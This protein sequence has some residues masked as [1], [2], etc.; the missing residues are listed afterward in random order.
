MLVQRLTT[1]SQW[2]T[3]KSLDLQH[4]SV[5][6]MYML[7][8]WL[9]SSYL[10]EVTEYESCFQQAPNSTL[11]SRFVALEASAPLKVAVARTC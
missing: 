6:A 4:L 10:C 1:V 9:I 5:S 2:E 11:S 3:K 7:S 8:P